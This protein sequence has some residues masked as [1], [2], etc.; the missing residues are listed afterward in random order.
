MRV[1]PYI[2]QVLA[3]LGVALSLALQPI[4]AW[5]SKPGCVGKMWNP[6]GDLDFK[7]MGGIKIGPFPFMATPAKLGEPPKHKV[8]AVC[9]CK[10]GLK[11]G[12]G[13]TMTFWM[14]SY[15]TDVARQGG[16]LGFMAGTNIL[17]GFI[18]LSSAQEYATHQPRVEGV[19]NMQIHWVYADVTAIAG[20]ALFE[21]CDAVRAGMSIAYMTEADFPWQHDVWTASM[22]PLSAIVAA[23]PVLSQMLC[24]YESMANTL[25]DWQDSGLCAWGGSRLPLTANSAGK[26]SAQVS[27]MDVAVKYLARSALMG[28]TKRTMGPDAIC[29]PKYSMFYDPFQH[30]YQPA[31]PG[32][33]STRF[34]VD[35]LKWGM[36]LRDDGQSG[37]VTLD[38]ATAQ[39]H[40]VNS[41]LSVGS[42]YVPSTGP[43]ASG[44][45]RSV[46]P[47]TSNL[48]LAE[49]IMAKI[50]KPLNYPTKEAGF[51]QVWEARQCCMMVL[52]VENVI[53]MIIK[54][55]ATMGNA[56]IAELYEFYEMA[57]RAYTVTQFGRDPIG[58]TL[59]LVGRGMADAMGAAADGLTKGMTQ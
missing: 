13:F 46:K 50:P 26:S 10:N 27:N 3:S 59:D 31:F 45:V 40:N 51:M 5:A 19:T 58:S 24:G 2:V 17:P 39:L 48:S 37:M 25:G 52:T 34:N 8:D 21:K 57:E 29:R 11:S 47:T 49:S 41:T 44:E 55:M 6:L 20:K 23:N 35:M 9:A 43:L 7:L 54:N 32:K 53:K 36:S 22:F 4:P 33:T 16:C 1:P 38:S 15:I 14:P 30:R 56:Q 18:S 28:T 12:A 42:S